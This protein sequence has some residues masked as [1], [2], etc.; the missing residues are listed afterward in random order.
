MK[1]LYY[2]LKVYTWL[3]AIG[4]FFLAFTDI[5]YLIGF[6]LFLPYFYFVVWKL[7]WSKVSHKI[8]VRR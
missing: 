1:T 4:G 8:Y 5:D 7:K 2:Y 3:V 6:V